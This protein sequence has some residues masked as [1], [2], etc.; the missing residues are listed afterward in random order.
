[1]DQTTSAAV[2]EAASYLRSRLPELPQIA[3]VLG[4]GLGGL[5]DRLEQPVFI[6][7]G[8]VPHF[9]VSTAPGH[10]GR[11]A[12]GRLEGKPVLCM[13]GRFHYYEGYDMADIALPV[14]VL[15]A[16]GCRAMIL[17]NAAGGVNWDF[18]VGDFMLISDHINF[19]GA[20]PLRGAN[21]DAVGPRFCDMTQV[22]SAEL[23]TLARKIAAQQGIDLREGVYLG[24]MGP[25]FET[26]AEIRAFRVLGAD[27]VGMSTVPEAIAA[28]HCGLP[29]LG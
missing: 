4:S 24:Y 2:S 27:A 28:A 7:Y 8:Q 25:S 6:P 16:L 15:R 29:V 18:S 23:Q 5:A 11:F 13:Q 17:T 22:Y 14:R 3:L 12:A 10:A 1:M 21:D 26:P 9:P 19:M 20:N